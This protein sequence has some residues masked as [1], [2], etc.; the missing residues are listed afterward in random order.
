MV[1][2]KLTTKEPEAQPPKKP[3]LRIV[4]RMEMVTG[5]LTEKEREALHAKIKQRAPRGLCVECKR[6]NAPIVS[7]F[8]S[9]DDTTPHPT[10]FDCM[11]ARY[12]RLARA[13]VVYDKLNK[14]G[15]DVEKLKVIYIRIIENEADLQAAEKKA[16]IRGHA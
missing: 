6:H 5:P 16:G 7:P 4:S 9:W 14:R 1:V 15:T 11:L 13:M 8:K 10:C 2:K 12:D 3:V